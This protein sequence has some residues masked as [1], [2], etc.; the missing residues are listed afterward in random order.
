MKYLYLFIIILSLVIIN[1]IYN[2]YYYH[3]KEEKNFTLFKSL[4]IPEFDFLT[5][6]YLSNN[7]GDKE[8]Y[9]CESASNAMPEE[10]SICVYDNNY[11]KPDN[12]K[13]N[14]YKKSTIKD[15]IKNDLD[16]DKWYFKY[17]DDYKFFKMIGMEK[18]FK[19]VCKNVFNSDKND[20]YL[21]STHVFCNKISNFENKIADRILLFKNCKLII[22][23]LS[24]K[25]IEKQILQKLF[26]N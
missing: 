21:N 5:F 9:L 18:K 22:I 15:F 20:K 4:N 14:V 1:Y 12:F 2:Y 16:D 10:D 8:I 23:F 6:D 13:G 24:K 7:H 11:I 25:N 26:K 3:Y 19:N 17:E